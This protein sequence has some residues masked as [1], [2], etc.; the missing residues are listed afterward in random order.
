ML[1]WRNKQFF[2]I[3]HYAKTDFFI[4]IISTITLQWY[5]LTLRL[6]QTEFKYEYFE[7]YTPPK[8]PKFFAVSATIFSK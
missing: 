5:W 8:K 1:I 4:V 6:F 2:P 7:N 3:M